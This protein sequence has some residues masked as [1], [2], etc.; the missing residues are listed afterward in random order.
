MPYVF[1]PSD[2]EA[3]TPSQKGLLM[4]QLVRRAHAARARAIGH[5]LLGW[6]RY[7]SFRRQRREMIELA[8]MDDMVLRD[9]GINRFEIG[10]ALRSGTSLGCIDR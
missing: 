3:L 6:A 8:A 7:L 5:M 9:V 4:H 1:R 2:W 10:A